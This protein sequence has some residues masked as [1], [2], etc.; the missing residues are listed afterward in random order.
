MSLQTQRPQRYLK[1]KKYDKKFWEN[2]SAIVVDMTVKI[3]KEIS[4]QTSG[5][6]SGG[7][8]GRLS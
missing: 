4:S 7:I 8:A 1:K 6:I 3:P 5:V 2:L